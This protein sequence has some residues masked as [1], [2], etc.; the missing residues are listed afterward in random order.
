MIWSG[1]AVLN[2]LNNRQVSLQIV[3]KRKDPVISSRTKAMSPRA[4]MVPSSS[5]VWQM[6][7][8]DNSSTN[9]CATN[10]RKTGRPGNSAAVCSVGFRGS[11]RASVWSHGSCLSRHGVGITT[12]D[13]LQ[14]AKPS[15]LSE[16]LATQSSF[17][18]QRLPPLWRL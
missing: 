9:A 11:P 4:A 3:C 16:E 13:P 12:L 14:N 7:S 2:Q 5:K 15:V 8:A 1:P 10:F 18:T 6:G 17:F